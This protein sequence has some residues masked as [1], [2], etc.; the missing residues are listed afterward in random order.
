MEDNELVSQP[1]VILPP[2]LSLLTVFILLLLFYLLFS[3]E[4]Y[5]FYASFLFLFYSFIGKMWVSVI[6]IGVFQTI[7]MIPF[8]ILNLRRTMHIKEF[9]EKVAK[10]EG[11]KGQRLALKENIMQGNV[12]LLWYLINFSAQTI[13]YF[14]LGRLFLTDFYAQ[15][16]NPKLLY[17]FV[18][19]PDYPIKDIYFKIPY[20][21]FTKSRDFGLGWVLLVWFLLI[22]YKIFVSRFIAYYQRA[23]KDLKAGVESAFPF[24]LIKNIINYSSGSVTIFMALAWL[25]IRHFPT[26][27][28]FG[29]FSGDVSRPNPT[30]N[31][32]TAILT[33]FIVIWLDLPKI[34]QKINMAGQEGISP[35]IIKKTQI[36]LFKH[37]FQKAI[38]LG[39]GAFFITNLIPSAFELS[40]FTLEIISLISPFTLDRF[41][42][43]IPKKA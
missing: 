22:L 35:K 3:G 25:L 14:S 4:T 33:A 18:P 12:T 19:Y 43:R 5:R 16:L 26:A 8:R 42:L 30:F 13:A 17:S 41:V 1:H 40:I 15:A 34:S 31:L 6:C 9:K 37:T 7:L 10:I 36:Q 32:I 2:A 28:Q 11:K 27:W 23:G 20:F 24:S 21:F 38:I 39:T 29:I